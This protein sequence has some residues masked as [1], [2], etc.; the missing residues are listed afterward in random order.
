MRWFPVVSA[1]HSV[2]DMITAIKTQSP[3]LFDQVG[4]N[5]RSVVPEAMW[6]LMGPEDRALVDSKML[7]RI[8]RHARANEITLSIDQGIQKPVENFAT[9]ASFLTRKP[10]SI[11]G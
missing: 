8:Y 3:G 9:D 4:H 10:G 1:Q 5:Y 6:Q 11:A 2:S 7:G